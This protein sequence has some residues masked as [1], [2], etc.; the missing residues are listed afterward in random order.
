[1]AASRIRREIGGIIKLT[2]PYKAKKIP[3]HWNTSSKRQVI[4]N[5]VA[6]SG[7]R[8]TK[9]GTWLIHPR[10]RCCPKSSILELTV[11]D[12]KNI[13]PGSQVNSVLYVGF[14]EVSQGGIIVLG[15]SVKIK[16]KTIGTV[17]G[18]SDIHCPNHLN[19]MVAGTKEFATEYIEPTSDAAIVKM[20]LNLEDE[21]VFGKEY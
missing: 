20:K 12:E 15:D 6:L 11:T 10:T 14:F 5:I 4:G 8:L 18:F 19:I 21:V 16:S 2:E 17:A 9:R 13:E 1:L 3:D 7:L